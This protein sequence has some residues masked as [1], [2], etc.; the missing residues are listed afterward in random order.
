MFLIYETFRTSG[1]N[2]LSTERILGYVETED[3]AEVICKVLREKAQ[4]KYKMCNTSLWFYD[5][6][7]VKH[8]T[9]EDA[10]ILK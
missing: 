3:E 2:N 5:F 6:K 4:E 8:F 7:P 9:V 10:Q 1:M